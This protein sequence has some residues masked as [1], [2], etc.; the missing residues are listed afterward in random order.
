MSD[1]LTVHVDPLAEF[2]QLHLRR[3][4]SHRPHA[5]AQIFTADEAIFV[6]V[7]LFERVPQL[8]RTVTRL[9][10]LL[11]FVLGQFLQQNVGLKPQR[12]AARCTERHSVVS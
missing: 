10:L 4:V 9:L 5:V 3:H 1:V 2:D 11:L 12:A 7:E 8:C 6:F